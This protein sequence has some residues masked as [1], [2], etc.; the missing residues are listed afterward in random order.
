MY[1]S[2]MICNGALP[3]TPLKGQMSLENPVMRTEKP[4]PFGGGNHLCAQNVS[5]G[6]AFS[7]AFRSP[8]SFCLSL[9]GTDHASVTARSLRTEY[10][11]L[12]P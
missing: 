11:M 10:R 12:L 8:E 6:Q 4:P 5:F 9:F 3:H 1:R 7:K 2:A